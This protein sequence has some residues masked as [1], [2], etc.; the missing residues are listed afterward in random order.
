MV[1]PRVR[2]REQNRAEVAR[3]ALD[4]FTE[5]GFDHV[6][7]DDIAAA[8]GISRRTFFRYFESKEAAALPGAHEQISELRAALAD[9]PRDEP[10]V[11]RLRRATLSLIDESIDPA[12]TRAR[13]RIIASSPSVR[14]HSLEQQTHFEAELRQVIAEHLGVDEATH[15]G[16][17]VLAAAMIAAVR[18]A[19]EVWLDADDG[20]SLAD[21]LDEAHVVLMGESFDRQFTC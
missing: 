17:R 12:E 3:V 19:A 9:Q 7:V 10:L 8:A 4:L 21:V 16:A 6:T 15:V 14:A 1:D 11:E 18:A 5:R 20:R 13:L 2:A